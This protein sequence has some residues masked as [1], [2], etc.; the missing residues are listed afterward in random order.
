MNTTSL[1]PHPFGTPLPPRTWICR[2]LNN[3]PTDPSTPQAPVAPPTSQLP[4]DVPSIRCAVDIKCVRQSICFSATTVGANFFRRS[5]GPVY[6]IHVSTALRSSIL[7]TRLLTIVSVHL[8]LRLPRKEQT[9]Q[10]K[11]R[12]HLHVAIKVTEAA[13]RS[14]DD[15]PSQ[16]KTRQGKRSHR[17]GYGYPAKLNRSNKFFDYHVRRVPLEIHPNYYHFYEW[18]CFSASDSTFDDLAF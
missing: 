7:P 9:V 12:V 17:L 14:P 11:F 10:L 6:A 18:L 4:V 15:R 1:S 13:H 16:R 2:H 3:H 5:S 8:H